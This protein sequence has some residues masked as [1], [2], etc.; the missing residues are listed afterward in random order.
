[1]SSI[2]KAA[3]ETLKSVDKLVD[4]TKDLNAK[5]HKAMTT[6]VKTTK[7]LEDIGTASWVITHAATEA[8]KWAAV[9]VWN[10]ENDNEEE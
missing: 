7:A 9:V 10:Q 2:T 6:K 3:K 1:M 4:A 5:I 8:S